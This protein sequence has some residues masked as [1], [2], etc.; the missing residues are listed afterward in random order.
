[1]LCSLH[2]ADCC[3]CAHRLAAG[4]LFKQ[5]LVHAELLLLLPVAVQ[6]VTAAA[7]ALLRVIALTAWLATFS[8]STTR[9]PL[10]PVAR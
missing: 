9:P 3:G 8:N 10:S 2:T 6:S 5:H 4:A 7:A 1:M